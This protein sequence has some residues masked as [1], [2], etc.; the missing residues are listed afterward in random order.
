MAT[1]NKDTIPPIKL[2]STED[3]L[4]E[5]ESRFDAF[6]YHGI[7]KNYKG[8]ARDR[9]AYRFHGNEISCY[10]LAG[11]M[12]KIIEKYIRDQW[13]GEP[14]SWEEQTNDET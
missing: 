2:V 5:L 9:Y 14:E 11:H 8:P 13:S 3:L 6:I 4:E 1:E 12:K 7:K 10:G